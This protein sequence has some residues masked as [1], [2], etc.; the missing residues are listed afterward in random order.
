MDIEFCLNKIS[1]YSTKIEKDLRCLDSAL[2]SLFVASTT[3]VLF[4]VL[5][6]FLPSTLKTIKYFVF[7]GNIKNQINK[8]F[9][10]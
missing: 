10:L 9:C 5:G 3:L 1:K 8:F 6:S 7:Y 2:V 4:F